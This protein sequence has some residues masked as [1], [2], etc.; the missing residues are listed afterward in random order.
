[1]DSQDSEYDENGPSE[2][3]MKEDAADADNAEDDVLGDYEAK[4]PIETEYEFIESQPSVISLS[5]RLTGRSE[6]RIGL[7]GHFLLTHS[8]IQSH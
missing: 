6:I 5:D 8:R 4:R 1:M 2:E 3:G 7:P